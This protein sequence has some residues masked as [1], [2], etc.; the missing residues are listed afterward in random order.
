MYWGAW[1]GDQI[2]GQ[3]PPWDMNAATR[4]E[5]VVGKRMSMVEF[6]SPFA[7]CSAACANFRFPREGM[8]SIRQHGAIPFFSWGSESSPRET[9]TQADYQLSDLIEG[10]HDAYIREFATEAAA[11][12]HPFFLRFDWEMNGNW[13]PWGEGVNGNGPGQYAA[14][15]RHV[16]DIFAAAGATNVSWVW[17]P[18]VD[19]AHSFADVGSFYPGDAYVDWTGL[20]GYNWGTNPTSPRGW[21]SF[22]QLFAS[23]Y[24][25]IAGS[26]A[27]SKPM[28]VA[29][30]GSSEQGGSK[31]SWIS[32]ALG[33][34]PT[35][36]PSI[37]AVLWFDKYDDG[38]DW[39]LETSSAATSAF[40]EGIQ[41]PS[42]VGNSY[43][44]LSGGPIQP[45]S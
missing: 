10:R 18:F 6:S 37:R 42:Y 1:I 31:A 3:A 28:M 40:A 45:P 36:Y 32:D 12:G 17:C 9:A 4:F 21:K 25:R 16:H 34:I 33:S 15:W 43:A 35:Q 7:D 27:P 19:P 44:G 8:E 5:E 20:D 38:M 23:T 2:T 24:D 11:W 39:P 13:F 22:E 14:A 29:E 30:M 26:V 41:Q